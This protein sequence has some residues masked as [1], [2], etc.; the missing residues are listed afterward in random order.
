MAWLWLCKPDPAGRDSG[1]R[2][3][4][5][6]EAREGQPQARFQPQE[7]DLVPTLSALDNDGTC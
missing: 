3:H 7:C 5:G 4:T 2:R 6:P 1:A